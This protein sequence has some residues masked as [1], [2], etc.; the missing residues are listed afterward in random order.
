MQLK[1][2]IIIL[3]VIFICQT[4]TTTCRASC[5]LNCNTQLLLTCEIGTNI[6]TKPLN[7]HDIFSIHCNHFY[8]KEICDTLSDL[9]KLTYTH[10]NED[11]C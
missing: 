1:S 8:C 10:L 5:A 6:P 3:F 2:F 9:L 11:E 4:L 7:N